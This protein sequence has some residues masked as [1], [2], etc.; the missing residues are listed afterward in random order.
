MAADTVEHR[1]NKEL[2]ND[3]MQFCQ[4]GRYRKSALQS[5]M[6]QSMQTVASCVE[7]VAGSRRIA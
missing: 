4:K 3:P 7:V 5:T 1:Q 6:R 2:L